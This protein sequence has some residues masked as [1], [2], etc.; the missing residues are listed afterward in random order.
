MEPAGPD[1]EKWWHL[2]PERVRLFHAVLFGL[3][4]NFAQN[5][6]L[7]GASINTEDRGFARPYTLDGSICV[8]PNVARILRL[9]ATPIQSSY[10]F[11]VSV[12]PDL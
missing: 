11:F 4:R 1:F 7:L 9:D 10:G 3:I 8:S 6:P 5:I 12:R 2:D